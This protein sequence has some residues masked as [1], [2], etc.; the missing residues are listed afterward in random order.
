MHVHLGPMRQIDSAIYRKL[1][2]IRF[3]S[4]HYTIEII[5]SWIEY[6]PMPLRKLSQFN[7]DSIF[8]F[9]TSPNRMHCTKLMKLIFIYFWR[10]FF[11]DM[12]ANLLRV[13]VQIIMFWMGL[14]HVIWKRDFWLWIQLI[15]SNCAMRTLLCTN[16][17]FEWHAP[18]PSF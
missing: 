17:T 1:A 15:A 12:T 9:L 11:D 5:Q 8:T 16:Y 10:Q 18:A 6:G 13:R 4:L 14:C 7:C 3:G 2:R